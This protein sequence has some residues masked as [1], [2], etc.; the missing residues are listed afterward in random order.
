MKFMMQMFM[1]GSTIPE[2]VQMTYR[3]VFAD[4]Q[5]SFVMSSKKTQ[6][7]CLEHKL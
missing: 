1:F 3:P 5:Q 4:T 2:T 7:A 6:K